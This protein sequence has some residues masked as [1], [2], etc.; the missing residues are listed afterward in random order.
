L[1]ADKRPDQHGNRGGRAW[2][3]VGKWVRTRVGITDPRKAPDHSWRH[4]VEDEL[5]AAEVPEDARDAI[6]GHARK[7]T[8]RQYGVRGEALKRLARAIERI[9]AP[10]GVE[11]GPARGAMRQGVVQQFATRSAL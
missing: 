11:P 4:R 10:P 7:T 8:G 1:F 5:R 2:N 3:V 9:P 6:M